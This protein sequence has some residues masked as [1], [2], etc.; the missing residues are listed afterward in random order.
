MLAAETLK[1]L[2]AHLFPPRSDS[3]KFL[4]NSVC[5]FKLSLGMKMSAVIWDDTRIIIPM[6]VPM[7]MNFRAFFHSSAFVYFLYIFSN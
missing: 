5:V 6:F 4:M 3:G 2:L 7:S 1:M